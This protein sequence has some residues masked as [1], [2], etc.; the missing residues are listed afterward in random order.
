M[1]EIT[2][3]TAEADALSEQELALFGKLRQWGRSIPLGLPS[4]PY[5]SCGGGST[6]SVWAISALKLREAAAR[7]QRQVRTAARV[8]SGQA[9]DI[10]WS[11]WRWLG[12]MYHVVRTARAAPVQLRQ[13]LRRDRQDSDSVGVLLA[14]FR[15]RAAHVVQLR[16]IGI[17][18][19]LPQSA[20]N[21]H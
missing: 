14:P 18:N 13:S 2:S 4:R 8:G 7:L 12:R 11:R 20:P 21:V 15:T 9:F 3:E 6:E 5:R 16:A 1:K 17:E 19:P 10:R